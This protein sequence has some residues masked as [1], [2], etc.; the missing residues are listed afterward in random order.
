[1]PY[2]YSTMT[3]GTTFAVYAPK[4]DPNSLSRVV[5]RIE[6]KGGH[7]LKN[8]QAIDTPIGVVTKVTD[9][10]LEL[11]EQMVAFRQ[12]VES[13]FLVVDKKQSDPE[14]KAA[15]MNPKDNSAPLTPKD[16]EKSEELGEDVP[17][18]K[19]KRARL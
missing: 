14:K 4:T 11:L 9:E 3:C 16:F 1:M 12:Q 19:S 6:I 10:E 7:G 8:P 2:I 5:K 18:Y 13:G 15:S 17:T